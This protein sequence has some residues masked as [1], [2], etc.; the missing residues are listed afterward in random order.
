M[1]WFK[2]TPMTL[3]YG[4]PVHQMAIRALMCGALKPDGESILTSTDYHFV[5]PHGIVYQGTDKTWRRGE[6]GFAS[7]LAELCEEIQRDFNERI[8]AQDKARE[9]A[10]EKLAVPPLFA[11]VNKDTA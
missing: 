5:G 1:G 11:S 7:G 8:A 6:D 3:K 10:R 2:P 9:Y 4:E